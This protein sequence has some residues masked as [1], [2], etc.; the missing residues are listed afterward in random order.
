[1]YTTGLYGKWK[2]IKLKVII[3]FQ[4]VR[5]DVVGAINSGMHGILVKTGMFYFF[6]VINAF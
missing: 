1:M 5:G 3:I 6:F 2:C 4:D